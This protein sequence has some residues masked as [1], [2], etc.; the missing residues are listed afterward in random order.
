MKLLEKKS[1]LCV[2]TIVMTVLFSLL[3]GTRANAQALYDTY[4]LNVGDIKTIS[5]DGAYERT[6]RNRGTRILSTSWS[7]SD[8]NS[9]IIVSRNN[10]A[11]TIR[12][13]EPT[14]CR[15][16]YR[17]LYNINGFSR[18]FNFYW[19]INVEYPTVYV[20]S[21]SLD[22][23]SMELMVGDT[24]L[25]YETVRPAN[26]SNTSVDWYSSSDSV[27]SVSAGGRV[28]AHKV[29]EATISCIS[30]DGT[31][32]IASC[33]VTVVPAVVTKV[34]LDQHSLK[35][36]KDDTLRL[37]PTVAPDS[38]KNKDVVWSSSNESVA[39]VSSD[40]LVT[41]VGG[42]TSTIFCRS[43]E[44]SDKYDSCVV[45]VDVQPTAIEFKDEEISLNVGDSTQ[46]D[47][48]FI[49]S[50]ATN[51][52]L[53]WTIDKRTVAEVS[54]SG[55]VKAISAGTAHVIAS[56]E[57]GLSA[58]ITVKVT[59]N[60]TSTGI[61]NIASESNGSVVVY[62]LLGTKIGI[63]AAADLENYLK[64]LPRGIYI[65]NGLKFSN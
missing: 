61:S 53:S 47:V 8:P 33:H 6:L 39:S 31:N 27:A 54:D 5:I 25:L 57:N 18:E 24:Y 37:K 59:D 34:T 13:V 10:F 30:T 50:D 46:L 29:G 60:G 22:K 4:N 45:F 63:V 55:L 44:S 11:A 51:R 42:G 28:Y 52:A 15:I 64:S 17:C 65:V 1:S 56:T 26:A 9:V 48:E 32:R 38:A 20:T 2:M 36:Q 41:A 7:S 23:T 3:S 16:Y 43:I 35:M 40:G 58:I 49:P 19:E 14:S 62:S 12:C 21:I